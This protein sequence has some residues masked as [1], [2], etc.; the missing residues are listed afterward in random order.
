MAATNETILC[1]TT[2]RLVCSEFRFKIEACLAISNGAR[3]QNVVSGKAAVD[4]DNFRQGSRAKP[5]TKRRDSHVPFL[6][7]IEELTIEKSV[8]G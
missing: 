3:S 4:E 1:W 2:C 6:V 5:I 7:E 8:K